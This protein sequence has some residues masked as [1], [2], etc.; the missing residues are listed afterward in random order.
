M[1]LIDTGKEVVISGVGLRPVGLK[2]LVA[3][4][5]NASIHIRPYPNE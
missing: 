4:V 2:F 5:A 3:K 1:V